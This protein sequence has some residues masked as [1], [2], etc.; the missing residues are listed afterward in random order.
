MKVRKRGG[1]RENG[2]KESRVLGLS[3]DR[4]ERERVEWV[5]KWICCSFFGGVHRHYLKFT[6]IICFYTCKILM[7]QVEDNN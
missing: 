3:N 2:A 4:M 5:S 6:T 7:G 1:C